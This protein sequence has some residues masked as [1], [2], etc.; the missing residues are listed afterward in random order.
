MPAA[1]ASAQVTAG[2][3]LRAKLADWTPE[4]VELVGTRPLGPT[5]QKP[6]KARPV[7]RE[8]LPSDHYGVLAAFRPVSA[9]GD[10]HSGG[11]ESGD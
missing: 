1:G 9:G 10:G 7:P 5:W 4:D 11:T 6:L 8:T 3:V 2:P